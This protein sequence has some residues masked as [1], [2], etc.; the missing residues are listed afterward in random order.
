MF[1]VHVVNRLGS[2]SIV[3]YAIDVNVSTVQG[4]NIGVWLPMG[5]DHTASELISLTWGGSPPSVTLVLP[6]GSVNLHVGHSYFTWNVQGERGFLSQP[7]FRD[8]A[9]FFLDSFRFPENASMVAQ[10][11]VVLT[12][13]YENPAQAYAMASAAATVVCHYVPG[14]NSEGTAPYS[15][16]E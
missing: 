5:G 4:E 16:C 9:D 14:P 7:I 2:D 12:W 13:Y 6:A 8:S 3:P 15:A 1:L 10:V 11:D